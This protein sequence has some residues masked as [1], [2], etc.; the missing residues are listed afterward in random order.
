MSEIEIEELLLRKAA[1]VP[2]QIYYEK[3][4]LRNPEQA[5]P[6]PHDIVERDGI[7]WTVFRLSPRVE[8]PD[9]LAVT[10]DIARSQG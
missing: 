10:R 3:V 9:I 1:A 4:F 2:G 8:E 7:V 6:P 5:Q